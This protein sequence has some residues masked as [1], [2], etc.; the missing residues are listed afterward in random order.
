MKEPQRGGYNVTPM[1]NGNLL[2]QVPCY[3]FTENVRAFHPYSFPVAHE[4]YTCLAG[5]GKSVL[6]CVG[7]SHILSPNAKKCHLPVLQSSRISLYPRP[8]WPHWLSSIVTSGKT[9]R[10]ITVGY[11]HLYWSSFVVSPMRTVPF[12]PTS[13]WAMVVGR[14]MPATSNFCGASGI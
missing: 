6:W 13:M 4:V 8:D 9:K 1:P 3:G 10:R 5:A 14:N 11:C 12:F 2:V 7:A